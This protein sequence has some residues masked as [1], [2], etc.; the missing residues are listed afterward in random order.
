[1]HLYLEIL[2]SL[3]G[4]YILFSIVNSAIVEGIAQLLNTRGNYLKNKLK[5]FFGKE[6]LDSFYNKNLVKAYS[7]YRNPAFIDKSIFSQSLLEVL[8]SLK[9]D[10]NPLET[11]KDL[12]KLLPD[13]LRDSFQFILKK[14]QAQGQNKL[15]FVQDEIEKLYE[16]YMEKIA[17]WYKAYVRIFLGIAGFI[18]A[19]VFNINSINMYNIL[20]EDDTVRMKQVQLSTLLLE[21]KEDIELNQQKITQIL[22]ESGIDSIPNQDFLDKILNAVVLK[23]S[24]KPLVSSKS[25]GIGWLKK[26]ENGFWGYLLTGFALSLGSTFWFSFLKKLL[27]K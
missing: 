15:Q 4:L 3:V 11:D 5:A 25:L 1:M 12:M 19:F 22:V 24:E 9:D 6:L 17:T 18:F 8:L 14:A 23:E 10:T 16:A 26:S 27:L 13:S 21:R 2:I 20:S 7:N